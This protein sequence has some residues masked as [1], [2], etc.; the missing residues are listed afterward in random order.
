MLPRTPIG[1][2]VSYARGQWT[3]LTRSLEDGDLAID[4]NAAERALRRVVTGRKYFAGWLRNPRGQPPGPS[5]WAATASH[6]AATPR[7]GTT[8]IRPP[9]SARR[10]V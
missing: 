5:S 4:N 3:A 7:R 8:R 2:A 10:S 6:R 9:P 1:E